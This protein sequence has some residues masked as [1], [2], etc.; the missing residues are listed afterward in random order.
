MSNDEG[1]PE[2]VALAKGPNSVYIG[3]GSSI[4]SK[5]QWLGE[6]NHVRH[7]VPYEGFF[8]EDAELLACDDGQTIYSL[9]F[10]DF[11]Y[12]G[13]EYDSGGGGTFP[14]VRS[15]KYVL[16]TIEDSRFFY[17]IKQNED[18]PDGSFGKQFK[19][20]QV[21]IV[22][23]AICASK[24]V[25]ENM[26]DSDKHSSGGHMPYY[27]TAWDGSN[28]T[29][30]DGHDNTVTYAWSCDKADQNKIYLYAFR[31]ENPDTS[32]TAIKSVSYTH[33]TLPTI[34]LV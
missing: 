31:L 3:T 11:P 28:T 5:T 8:L 22:P 21:P 9:D 30:I 34:L 29:G 20:T 14:G 6:I 15:R 33:L 4:S 18:S 17:C 24:I 1:A 25:A 27:N 32:A 23:S 7:G 16:S 10:M 2:S 13:D 19:T 12:I 26:S